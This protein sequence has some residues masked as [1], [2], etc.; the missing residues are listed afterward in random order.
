MYSSRSPFVLR[1]VG[2]STKVSTPKL[3]E[4]EAKQNIGFRMDSKTYD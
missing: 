2:L 1:L 3:A 4:T